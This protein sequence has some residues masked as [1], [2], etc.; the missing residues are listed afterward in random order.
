ME[1]LGTVRVSI[2]GGSMWGTSHPVI[3][4]EHSLIKTDALPWGT[5]PKLKMKPPQLKNTSPLPPLKSE[6]PLQEMIPVINTW[7]L[8]IKQHWQKMAEIPQEH[9]FLTWNIQNFVEKVKQFV[10]KCYI[11]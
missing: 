4:S 11:A 5:P 6:A 8:I 1:L 3:F 9:D 10:R 7:V 2:S